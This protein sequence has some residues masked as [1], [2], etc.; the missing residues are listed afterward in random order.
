[1]TDKL[2]DN[3]YAA[4][5]DDISGKVTPSAKNRFMSNFVSDDEDGDDKF[6]E[7]L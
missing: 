6:L 5:L 1:M 4:V 2:Q 3:I 7:V